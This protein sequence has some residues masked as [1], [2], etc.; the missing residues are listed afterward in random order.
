MAAS[1]EEASILAVYLSF[2]DEGVCG[3]DQLIL[4]VEIDWL[5]WQRLA[6]QLCNGR[7]L[8]TLEK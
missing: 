8:Q 6:A 1:G 7:S 2:L 4:L 5:A 3:A